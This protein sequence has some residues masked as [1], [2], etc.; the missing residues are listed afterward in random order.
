MTPTN[1]S[2]RV[3]FMELRECEITISAPDALSAEAFARA[4]YVARGSEPFRLIGIQPTAW[5]ITPTDAEDG[6]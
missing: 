5:L 6:Q 1:R 4:V 2:Y 3:S